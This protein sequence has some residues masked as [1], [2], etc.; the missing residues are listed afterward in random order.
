MSK[1]KRAKKGILK[2]VIIILALLIGAVC[3]IALF[4]FISKSGSEKK[5]KSQEIPQNSQD[6]NT[7]SKKIFDACQKEPSKQTCYERDIPKLMDTISMVDA[8]KVVSYVQQMDPSYQY[9]HTLGHALSAREV[10]K[11]PSKWKEVVNMC[12]RG[13]CSNGCIHGGF[14]EKFRDLDV[15]SNMTKKEQESIIEDLKTVCEEKP[16]WKPTGMEQ[17][18]CYHALGHLAMYI[19]FADTKEASDI[20]DTI[21]KKSDGRDFTAVC[22]DGVFMQIYQPLEDEDFALIKG[23]EVTRDT[24]LAAC[25]KFDGQKRGSCISEAWPLFRQDLDN[26]KNLGLICE[27][28]EE[29]YKDR[30]YIGLTWVMTPQLGFDLDKMKAYCKGYPERRRGQCYAD[31]V[32]RL[33]ETDFKNVDRVPGF[34]AQLEIESEKERCYHELV[35]YSTFNFPKGSPEAARMC[36]LMEEP[37]KTQCNSSL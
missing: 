29:A 22:Y 18:S 7:I 14:Q 6:I 37:W 30:C 25:N 1:K 19:T 5:T 21:S 36:G 10:Q 2:I 16:G 8:F 23:K 34:C 15:L 13:V 11:D 33:I 4:F 12:P 3:G 9:C 35:T 24:F 20:C 31:V 32:A 27:L 17:A 26:P 28:E